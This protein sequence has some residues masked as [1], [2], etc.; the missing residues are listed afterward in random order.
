MQLIKKQTVS[1]NPT[2]R[3]FVTIAIIKNIY[4]TL[5]QPKSFPF[6]LRPLPVCS[7]IIACARRRDRTTSFR[8]RTRN[9]NT[10]LPKLK[11]NFITDNGEKQDMCI[12]YS[13]LLFTLQSRVCAPFRWPS[14]LSCPC[15]SEKPALV[16]PAVAW[17]LHT[18]P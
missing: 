16:S 2:Q 3:C 5:L 18:L 1:K 9:R 7:G 17:L 10:R 6:F 15:G 12:I 13:N 11:G 4:E 14:P 8:I